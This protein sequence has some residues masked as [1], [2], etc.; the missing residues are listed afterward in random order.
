MRCCEK[1]L[2]DK[3]ILCSFAHLHRAASLPS[4]LLSKQ[5]GVVERKE[6]IIAGNTTIVKSP[7]G[8]QLLVH[9]GCRRHIKYH[10]ERQEIFIK[11]N[12][13]KEKM[14]AII[15]VGGCKCL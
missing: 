8:L 15:H 7:S 3:D 4:G 9:L 1:D 10:T 12:V 5:D 11:G 2:Y 14:I 6:E 13:Y